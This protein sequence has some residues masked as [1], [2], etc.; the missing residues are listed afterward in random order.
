MRISRRIAVAVVGL[1]GASF[2][3]SPSMH[4]AAMMIFKPLP[5][6]YES[7]ENP[8][9]QAKVEL[10]RLLF[11]E[12]RLSKGQT[13]SCATC[14]DLQ[15][16]GVDGLPK[17]PGHKGQLGRRNSPSAYNAGA[18]VGLFWD[19]RAASLEE[20]AK[21]PI[22]NPV[23][24]AMPDAAAVEKVIRSIPGYSPLF[25]KAFP[26]AKEP[27][28]FETITLAIAAF[29]RTLVTPSRFDAYLKGN[30]KALSEEERQGLLTFMSL[31][32]MVCHKGE[33]VG[34]GMYQALGFAAKVP[35]EF[36]ADP[37]RFEV[38]KREDDRNR[39]RVPSLRNVEKTAPYLHDGS[40]KTLD[41]VVRFMG[42]YQL[43]KDLTPEEVS[44]VITFLK[45]LTGELPKNV[46][47]P[48]P[49]PSGKDTPKP[50]PT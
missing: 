44:S 36:M 19:G 12:R 32:C 26:D 6:K 24:M 27:I 34:G 31:G 4:E 33:G 39:F 46:T 20:Q 21:G 42:R 43:G 47:A 49:L 48:D 14:H 23:E 17:S 22:L 3:E 41:E 38:T 37:G 28:T 16:F 11:F 9:T 1:A 8:V 25:A 50:D 13:L 2:A 35:P 45:A 30:E 40:L 15:R 29:E 10:G 18:H 7:P 5:A